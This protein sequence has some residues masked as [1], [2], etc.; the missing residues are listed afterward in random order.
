[1]KSNALF[2]IWPMLNLDSLFISIKNFCIF[3]I[4]T[5]IAQQKQK[6]INRFIAFIPSTFNVAGCKKIVYTLFSLVVSCYMG[7][8]ISFIVQSMSAKTG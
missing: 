5:H 8:S 3:F 4:T 1:M 7:T 6:E 2:L